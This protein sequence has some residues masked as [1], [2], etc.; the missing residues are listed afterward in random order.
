M[1]R[2]EDS[3]NGG[4]REDAYYFRGYEG[5]G[6]C[7]AIIVTWGNNFIDSVAERT[8]RS[9]ISSLIDIL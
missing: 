3:P 8:V 1:R 4:Y 9:C 6:Q 2:R 7:D 5:L